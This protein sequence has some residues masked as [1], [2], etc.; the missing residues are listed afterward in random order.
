ME[1]FDCTQ[2]IT[3][4]IHE[5]SNEIYDN[6]SELF[7]NISFK[8][9]INEDI[10]EIKKK[11]FS[12]Y[13]G[14]YFIEL[15]NDNFL[16]EFYEWKEKSKPPKGIV[17]FHNAISKLLKEQYLYNFRVIFTFFAEQGKTSVEIIEVT[18]DM[19][20]DGL[21]AVSTNNYDVWADNYIIELI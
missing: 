6:I 18:R 4:D 2:F 3:F 21:Y 13:I 11:Y 14:G 20:M 10:R 19:I 1:N 9:L 5:K 12:N 17:E 16:G 8:I 15:K 7:S